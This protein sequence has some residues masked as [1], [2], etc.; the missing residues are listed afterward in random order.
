MDTRSLVLRLVFLAAVAGPVV[1]AA[2]QE[3][4]WEPYQHPDHGYAIDLPLGLM[5]PQGE[6][7]GRLVFAEPD[8][9]AQLVLYSEETSGNQNVEEIAETFARSA[10]IEDVTY[11]KRGESWFVLSGYFRLADDDPQELIFYLKLMLSAD[12]S[13][14][15]MFALHYPRSD[16]E[17]FDP[18]VERL[19][20]SF[21]RPI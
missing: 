14:Y 16:K 1:P 11:R 15:A 6:A 13:R 3:L 20:A 8:G 7:E 19:E 12:R 4:G 5:E 17:R 10:G 21:R 18:I 2:A 9:T